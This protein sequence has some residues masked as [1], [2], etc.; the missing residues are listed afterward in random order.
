MRGGERRVDLAEVNGRVFVN[1]VSLGIYADAVQQEG[2]REAKLRTLFNAVPD[3][4]GPD[5]QAPDLHWTGPDGSVHA[6]GAVILVSNNPYRLRAL[7]PGTRPRLD[8]GRLGVTV[9]GPES[10][11]K[12]RGRA[13][14]QWSTATFEVR[15]GGGVP[16]GVDGEALVLDPP[17]RFVMRPGA[18]TVRIAPQHPG[19]SPSAALPDA[20]WDAVRALARLAAGHAAA[21]ITAGSQ[22]VPAAPLTCCPRPSRS[23]S[24]RRCIRP[25]WRP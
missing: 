9:V 1:N 20:P 2:Y 22:P 21:Q 14:R 5:G 12:P 4:L 19:A 15:S 7:D 24:R 6:S 11:G 10:A 25:R 23:R 8:S 17:L 18:L 16:A 3:A 13:V